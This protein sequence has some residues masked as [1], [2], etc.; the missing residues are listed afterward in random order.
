MAQH[1]WEMTIATSKAFASILLPRFFFAILFFRIIVFI[2]N[3]F[4]NASHNLS[5]LSA[6]CNNGRKVSSSY[7]NAWSNII[8]FRHRIHLNSHRLTATDE[9]NEFDKGEQMRIDEVDS[10]VI[11][12]TATWLMASKTENSAILIKIFSKIISPEL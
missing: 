9:L 10:M 1:S 6:H 2:I 3:V 12:I 7:W 11:A 5:F 4:R 8:I